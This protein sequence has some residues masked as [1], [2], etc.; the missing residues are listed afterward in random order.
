VPVTVDLYDHTARKIQAGEFPASDT[1]VVNLYTALPFNA[2]A[3]TKTAAESGATQLST[4]NGYTQNA[5]TLTGV[6]V[7]TVTTNDSRF[8]FDPVNWDATGSG[9]A[10][11]FAL[12]YSDTQANDPPL[13]RINFDGTV[14]AVA[15]TQFRITPAAG[16]F[17]P[18]TYT[19]A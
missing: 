2:S 5:K 7:A 18:V 17:I 3:T 9:I 4:A 6:N 14:T 8:T 10:A 19:P 12:I 11:A 16:G 15:G 13:A 1:Y